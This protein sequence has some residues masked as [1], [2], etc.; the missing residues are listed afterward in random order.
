MDKSLFRIS[1]TRQLWSN[2]I[3][4]SLRLLFLR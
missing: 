1:E 2:K 4:D 3:E